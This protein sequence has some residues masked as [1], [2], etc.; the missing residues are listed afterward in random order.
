MITNRKLSFPKYMDVKAVDLIDKLM[1]LD[2]AK[3][4][5]VGT[6]KT[7]DYEALKQHKF[8]KGID[9]KKIEGTAPP[10]P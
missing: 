5:G 2:P 10:I 1:C 7:N 4:L 9:F 6:D 8:F 3:R